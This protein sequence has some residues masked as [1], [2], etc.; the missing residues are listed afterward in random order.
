MIA[1]QKLKE[2]ECSHKYKVPD[3]TEELVVYLVHQPLEDDDIVVVDLHLSQ[4]EAT[5]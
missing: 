1:F 4:N 3:S 2:K 5:S